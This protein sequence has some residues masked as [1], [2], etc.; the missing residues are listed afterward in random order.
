MNIIITGAS[1]GLGMGMARLF[2]KQGHNLALCARRY[3]R[4]TILQ[5]ELEHLNPEIS[6]QIAALDVTEHD[7]VAL[8]FEAFRQAFG[9]IDR[10]VVN[11]GIGR[12]HPL[13]SGKINAN[14]STAQTNFVAAMVQIESAMV[15]FRQQQH[16]HLVA[17]SSV[18]AYHGLPKAQTVYAAT[19]AGVSALMQ[20]L[21]VELR[22]SPIKLSLIH[23]GY[24]RTEIND[25]APSM[26]FE[27]DVDTGSTA[28][29]NAM[30]SGRF[31][32]SVPRWP[33]SVIGWCLRHLPFNITRTFL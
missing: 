25:F 1:S 15:I 18:S 3:D 26:P 19:K 13:G 14:V 9:V 24:I 28:I 21:R 32:T 22:Q 29:V 2:A 23:P 31:A 11:A 10:I 6:V 27:V 8:T 30:N 5:Q 7:N 12:G 17:I 16:G 33:W 4:L 20:G